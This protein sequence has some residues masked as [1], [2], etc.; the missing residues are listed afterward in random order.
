MHPLLF[1]LLAFA[2]PPAKAADSYAAL[3]SYEGTWQVT[4][5]GAEKPDV[6]IN[7]CALLGQYFACAQNVN[8]SAGGLV[9]FIPQKDGAGHYYT[10]TIMPEGRATGLVDLRIDGNEWT[11]T[12]RRDEYG[13]T[14]YYRTINTFADKNHIHFE[15][16][17]STDN[18]DWKVTNS[19][20]EVRTTNARSGR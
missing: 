9:V 7:H 11:Y 16:A 5:K 17:E 1:A 10:Q 4:R 12:S 3:R 20:D 19:G 14:T 18:K 13:K 6:L 8:G 15:Q 2:A